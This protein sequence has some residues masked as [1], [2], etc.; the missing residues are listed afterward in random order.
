MQSAQLSLVPAQMLMVL[1]FEEASA[2][3]GFRVLRFAL[4][5]CSPE[6]LSGLDPGV[7]AFEQ[8]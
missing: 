3:S 7:S 8:C 5:H 6:G 4:Q 1:H 2:S